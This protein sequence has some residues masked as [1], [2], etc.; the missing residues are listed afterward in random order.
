M[1][2][3]F[4]GEGQTKISSPWTHFSTAIGRLGFP[5]LKAKISRPR[6]GVPST[7][8]RQTKSSKG[9]ILL[10]ATEI[11]STNRFPPFQANI[12]VDLT[13]RPK[14]KLGFQNA[15]A[16][17]KLQNSRPWTVACKSNATGQSGTFISNAQVQQSGGTF[18][19]THARV[20]WPG[21][22]YAKLVRVKST[23]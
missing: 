7:A 16:I 20:Q 19:N 4:Y 9:P 13:L 15:I 11:R 23:G 17:P 22:A 12:T 18:I 1:G 21:T 3:T 10:F 2:L 5:I 8:L 6:I 14:G